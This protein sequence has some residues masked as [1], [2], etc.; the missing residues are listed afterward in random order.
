MSRRIVTRRHWYT[1]T[2]PAEATGVVL[3]SAVRSGLPTHNTRLTVSSAYAT[4]VELPM[5]TCAVMVSTANAD[6]HAAVVLCAGQRIAHRV[7]VPRQC[8]TSVSELDPNLT[9]AWVWLTT[10]FD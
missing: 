6:R 1:G 7:P 9:H 2:E 4:R 3:L 5:G 10:T 8:V